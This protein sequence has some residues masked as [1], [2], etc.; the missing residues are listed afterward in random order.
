M[1]T[2]VISALLVGRCVSAKQGNEKDATVMNVLRAADGMQA[3]ILA[4]K[5]QY[6]AL[7]E[8]QNALQKELG[9]SITKG[10]AQ[11]SSTAPSAPPGIMQA[12]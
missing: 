4:L 10:S 11:P 2:A 1:V 5:A 6:R 7:E 12:V 9:T 8:K 3:N